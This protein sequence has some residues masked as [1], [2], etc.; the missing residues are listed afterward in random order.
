MGRIRSATNEPTNRPADNAAAIAAHAT[1]PPRCCLATTGPSTL[2][3]PVK[4]ALTTAAATTITHTHCRELNSCQPCRRSSIIVEGSALEA[5]AILIPASNAADRKNEAASTIKAQP[6][7][8]VATRTPAIAAPAML[9]KL[10]DIRSRA[11]AD[12]RCVVLTSCGTSPAKAGIKKASDAPLSTSS[13]TT[14]PTCT[15]LVRNKTAT[16]SCVAP[17]NNS[18]VIITTYRGSRSATTPATIKHTTCATDRPSSTSPSVVAV[19]P[20]RDN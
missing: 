3:P 18:A 1:A 4:Q 19:A 12:C 7:P 10:I 17:A 2:R 14:T 15:E 11:F 9:V 13:P 8:T 20:G 6:G 5:C 16:M